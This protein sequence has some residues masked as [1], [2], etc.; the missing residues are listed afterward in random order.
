MKYVSIQSLPNLH[1]LHMGGNLLENLP[2]GSFKGLDRLEKLF[3]LSNNLRDIEN[4]AFVG[5]PNL[6]WLALNN[7][8]L[9]VI[10]KTCRLFEWNNFQRRLL[11]QLYRKRAGI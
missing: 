3:L 4:Q 2:D 10:I 11:L 1:E 7:N 9:Y 5:I 6:L 8:L